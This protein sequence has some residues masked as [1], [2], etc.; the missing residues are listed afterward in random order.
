MLTPAMGNAD[1]LPAHKVTGW[2][3]GRGANE[4][5]LADASGDG[6][7]A[8]AHTCRRTMVGRA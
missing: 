7:R 5:G 2:S 1:W 6:T 3:A 4:R 8:L